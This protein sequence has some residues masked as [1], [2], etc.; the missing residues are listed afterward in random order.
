[1]SPVVLA[2]T[3]IGFFYRKTGAR[4][5]KRRPGFEKN[6]AGAVRPDSHRTLL[7]QGFGH[8]QPLGSPILMI[9]F[10]TFF[11]QA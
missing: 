5:V 1:V 4:L 8:I 9:M 7:R 11:L 3:M 10:F 6:A 2:R